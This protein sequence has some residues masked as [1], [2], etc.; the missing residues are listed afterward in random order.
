MA[1]LCV[2]DNE[3]I[4]VMTGQIKLVGGYMCKP[5]WK[6]AGFNS[7]SDP[8]KYAE[9]LEASRVIEALQNGENLKEILLAEENSSI[10]KRTDK[11]KNDFEQAGVS[12]L[13]GTKK[14]VSA[15]PELLNDDETVKYATSGL[16]DGNTVLMVCTD[17]RIIFIDKGMVYGIKSTEI[18]LDMVN[19]V[20][21]EKGMLMGSISI[22]N[23]AV[24]TEVKNVMKETAPKMIDAI[25]SARKE[26]MHPSQNNSQSSSDK[27]AKSITDQ[28]HELKS[29]VD[30]GILTQDEFDA[31]KKQLLNI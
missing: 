29:L 13:W 15:L 7:V 10:K 17:E 25:K 19:S 26:F 8:V 6:Q 22:V 11:I 30:E 2:V 1:K 21:Y 5:H 23:G 31:K 16:V 12:D 9:K 14:E 27:L 18:P 3:K 24:K 4:G 28:L 20:N